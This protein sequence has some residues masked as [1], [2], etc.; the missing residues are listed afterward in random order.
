MAKIY[1]CSF[2]I[3][4]DFFWKLCDC[5]F[6]NV[7]KLLNILSHE[8]KNCM[9][10]IIQY[11]TLMYV[12]I[13]MVTCPAMDVKGTY[14][15]QPFQLFIIERTRTDCLLLYNASFLRSDCQIHW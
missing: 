8:E 10:V 9:V 5:I 11:F 4:Q 6:I 15:E 1:H 14:I 13:G 2:I 12:F 7:S 3:W